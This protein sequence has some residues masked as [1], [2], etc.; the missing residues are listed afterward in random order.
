MGGA[1]GQLA[2]LLPS[3]YQASPPSPLNSVY[4][5]LLTPPP[6]LL[7]R[8]LLIKPQPTTLFLRAASCGCCTMGRRSE[9]TWQPATSRAPA[10]QPSTQVGVH[11]LK[12]PLRPG[13]SS[14]VGRVPAV[15]AQLP[16]PPAAPP[17]AGC[18]VG[19]QP[20]AAG[21]RCV[22]YYELSATGVPPPQLPP[23]GL[24]QGLARVPEGAA[25]CRAA[26]NLCMPAA[27]PA[28]RIC[29]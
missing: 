19:A 8:L 4:L 1:F 3:A 26:C 21:H 13:A 17:P 10:S 15:P 29:A 24:T 16:I 5:Q 25:G 9:S 27:P 23:G 7:L 12:A 14:S 28:K 18:L 6:L 22:L 20:L 11:Q 2:I